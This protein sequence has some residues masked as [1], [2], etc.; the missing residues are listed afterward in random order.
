MSKQVPPI[1]VKQLKLKTPIPA[2]KVC[3]HF[4]FSNS[5]LN[6]FIF[7]ELNIN[8]HKVINTIKM[9]RK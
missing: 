7:F 4:F 3:F 6:S 8:F 9:N 1:Q 5:K 2:L